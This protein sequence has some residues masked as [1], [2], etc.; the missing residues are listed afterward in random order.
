MT[1]TI[2]YFTGT[3]NSLKIAKDLADKLGA[4]L[5]PI[6]RLW[7]QE[8]VISTSEK[9]GFVHPLYWLGIPDIVYKFVDKINLDKSE[10]IFDI[11]TCGHERMGCVLSI[12]RK[13]LEKKSKALSGGFYIEMPD[14]YLPMYDVYPEE[15]QKEIFANADLKINEIAKLIKEN[16]K[17]IEKERLKKVG[18]IA[19]SRFRK[20]VHSKDEK[21]NL[22]ENCNSC[23][24]CEKVCPVNNIIMVE[25]KP[26][27][28]HNC[29]CCFACM[30]LCPQKSIQYKQKTADKGRYRHPDVKLKEIMSQKP[31]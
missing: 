21:F 5:I 3:G 12:M 8:S 27:W 22:D 30:H 7:Q 10:Y 17:K 19:N 23:G 6:A 29:Q 4:E 26:Q 31:G 11:I 13:L 18:K 1:T 20:K 9:V 2:Y 16:T 24:T 28:Q 15:R 14:N 25:D